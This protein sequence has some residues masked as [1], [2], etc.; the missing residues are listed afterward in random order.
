MNK[1]QNIF[2]GIVNVTLIAENVI[3]IKNVIKSCVNVSA[4]IQ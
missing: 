2:N 1:K 3:Q 4:K